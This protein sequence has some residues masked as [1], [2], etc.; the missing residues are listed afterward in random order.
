MTYLQRAL[1]RQGVRLTTG[2]LLLIAA[3]IGGR[4]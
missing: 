3:E 2:T 4:E 1:E